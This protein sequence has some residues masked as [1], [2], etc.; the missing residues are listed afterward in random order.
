MDKFMEKIGLYDLWVV[1]L[2]GAFFTTLLK[3]VYDFMV[4]APVQ[5]TDM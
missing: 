3:S 1:T 2:P 4:E 5:T